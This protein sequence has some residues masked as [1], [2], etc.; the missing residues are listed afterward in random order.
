ML[1]V[2]VKLEEVVV[3]EP[4]WGGA[5][6]STSILSKNFLLGHFRG[7]AMTILVERVLKLPIVPQLNKIVR[8]V[9]AQVESVLD[10]WHLVQ[11]R[12]VRHERTHGLDVAL[13]EALHLGACVLEALHVARRHSDADLRLLRPFALV[14]RRLLFLYKRRFFSTSTLLLLSGH[15]I[16]WRLRF[17]IILLI[18]RSFE[19][20][21]LILLK[22]FLLLCLV[23][24]DW[25]LVDRGP[26]QLLGV[27]F[28][29]GAVYLVVSLTDVLKYLEVV[30]DSVVVV[31]QIVLNSLPDRLVQAVIIV[32][33]SVEGDSTLHRR[34]VSLD[35][36]L[37]SRS[38][39]AAPE[40]DKWLSLVLPSIELGWGREVLPRPV[41]F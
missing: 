40:L 24:A 35:A 27:E 31:L 33:P 9:V 4:L 15:R 7:L 21:L 32:E 20:K 11:G 19:L 39:K 38:L 30:E 41:H 2:F 17:N 14:V 28:V 8:E 1:L 22:I 37:G 10:K 26:K 36:D 12:H 13:A 29:F 6:F 18:M 5:C 34:L 23:L 25:D 3:D 16:Y